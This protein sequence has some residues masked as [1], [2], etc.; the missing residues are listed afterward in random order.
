M[1]ETIKRVYSL[2]SLLRSQKFQRQRPRTIRNLEE[3]KTKKLPGYGAVQNL[4][5]KSFFEILSETSSGGHDNEK[6][7]L[8]SPG[9]ETD[10]RKIDDNI[11]ERKTSGASKIGYP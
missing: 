11:L 2:A 10:R 6:M 3:S 7:V 9:D 4:S 1:E 5:Q 8:L